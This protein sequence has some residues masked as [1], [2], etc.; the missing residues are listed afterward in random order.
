MLP[1]LAVNA[2]GAGNGHGLWDPIRAEAAKSRQAFLPIPLA[3]EAA[4]SASPRQRSIALLPI[5]RSLAGRS[6]GERAAAS[7]AAALAAVS[8]GASIV[9]VHD[10]RETVDALKV[11]N[12]V[13]RGTWTKSLLHDP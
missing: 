6:V 13:E 7:L 2:A 8:R 10:V 12:A 11:W 5:C 9:R 4:H 1:P 3:A